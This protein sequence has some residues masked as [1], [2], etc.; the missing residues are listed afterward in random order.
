MRLI[1]ADEFKRYISESFKQLRNEL[2][3]EK[4]RKLGEEITK[5]FLM[6]IDEQPTVYD[7]KE[8]PLKPIHSIYQLEN[9]T[10]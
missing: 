2:K 3:T 6:D 8:T 7:V 5:G 4:Y 1:D 9:T 10:I